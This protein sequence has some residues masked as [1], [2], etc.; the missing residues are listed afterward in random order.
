[1]EYETV[2]GLEVHLQLSTK[3]KAFCGCSNKFGAP[4]NSQSCPV[5]LGFPGSLPVLNKKALEY[6][7]KAALALNCR[8]MDTLKFDRKNYF[9]PDLP[10][11]FQI[12]QYDMPLS[13]SGFIDIETK[14]HTKRI[15]IT[16]AHLEEDAGKLIHEE[17]GASLV[18]YNRCGVPLL[19]IVSEPEISSPEEAYLYL[20]TLKAIFEYLEISTCNMEEG[21]LR[22]D[23]NLSLRPKGAKELGTKTEVK[24]MN[25]FKA[26][27]AA[28]EYEV[29]R[30]TDALG[31][32]QKIV[33]ETRLWD[34]AKQKTFSLRSKEEAQ[35][36][37][38]FPEP[39]LVPFS[40]DK[41]VVEEIRASLPELPAQRKK[42][43]SRDY[44]LS[45]YDS[46]NLVA[47]KGV[48]NYFEE[49]VKLYNKPKVLANWIIGDLAYCA[50]QKNTSQDKLG[51]ST[52]DL[53]GLIALVDDGTITAK[54]A[55]EILPSMIETKK[56]ARQIVEEKGLAQIKD[57]KALQKAAEEVLSENKQAVE[58]FAKGKEQALKFL[59]G[60][61][62]AKTKGKASP[63]LANEIILNKLKQRSEA[64]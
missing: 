63:E 22:C 39:D 53:T 48:A 61:F 1:M 52:K 9:Y 45:E 59:I 38:Y 32:G 60:K 46:S 21:S 29:K 49:S 25:S 56:S 36:Y 41:S 16:R 64:K 42:R 50:N 14:E 51:L 58:D 37:R 31:L 30:Q 44:G 35:D 6:A 18:D 47:E 28:L 55:K 5:C 24:N 33:Q 34:E 11:N 15:G 19:E 3:T 13:S 17:Q 26:V 27:K 57:T 40:I 2:I 20:M 8:I 7:V 10:K 23:A 43:F 4:P 54:T 12:S 62:M